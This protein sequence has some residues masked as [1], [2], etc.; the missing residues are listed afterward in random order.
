MIKALEYRLKTD[1]KKASL[2]DKTFAIICC[3]YI[4]IISILFDLQSAVVTYHGHPHYLANIVFSGMIRYFYWQ[5][6][7]KVSQENIFKLK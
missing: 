5:K 2:T 1:V 4:E 7:N 3:I 6:R